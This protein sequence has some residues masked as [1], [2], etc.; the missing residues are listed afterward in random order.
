MMS[1]YQLFASQA[2][3]IMKACWELVTRDFC[4][5]F[6]PKFHFVARV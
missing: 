5:F 6:F 4:G 2:P 1:L 3:F